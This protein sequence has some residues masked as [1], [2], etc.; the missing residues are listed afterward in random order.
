M[1][2]RIE[3]K[4]IFLFCLFFISVVVYFLFPLTLINKKRIQKYYENGHL[5]AHQIE[6]IN[7]IGSDHVEKISVYKIPDSNSSD[8][9]EAIASVLTQKNVRQVS[10][11]EIFEMQKDSF[12]RYIQYLGMNKLDRF[13]NEEFNFGC[14]TSLG[15]TEALVHYYHKNKN[16]FYYF[17]IL[18][19]KENPELY[20]FK[21]IDYHSNKDWRD[22]YAANLMYDSHNFLR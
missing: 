13:I 15:K 21:I 3:N 9:E 14:S 4:W 2:Y 7:K 20:V 1:N 10:G 19:Q 22:S 12:A 16:Y 18:S 11:E 8:I 6:I 5:D 17:S